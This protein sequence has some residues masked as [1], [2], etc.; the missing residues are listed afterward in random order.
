MAGIKIED[1][2]YVRFRAPDL[3]EMK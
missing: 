3:S 1:V 2:A